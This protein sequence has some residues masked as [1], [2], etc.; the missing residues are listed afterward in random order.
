VP[1]L[2]REC[3]LGCPVGPGLEVGRNRQRIVTVG[4]GIPVE[5]PR[6]LPSDQRGAFGQLAGTNRRAGSGDRV[7][8]RGPRGGKVGRG[9]GQAK[10]FAAEGD[11][12]FV[13]ED[14]DPAALGWIGL[15]LRVEDHLA[16]D[17]GIAGVEEQFGVGKRLTVG[18]AGTVR[19][20]IEGAIFAVVGGRVAVAAFA[21]GGG[22]PDDQEVFADRV[23]VNFGGPDI[24]G[25]IFGREDGGERLDLS[26]FGPA[27]QILRCRIGETV[28]RPVGGPDGVEEAVVKD[29]RGIAGQVLA[30]P[31]CGGKDGP[32]SL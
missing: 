9:E 22:G 24:A 25:L 32:S 10:V 8:R 4:E 18:G 16:V 12:L 3:Q 28:A 15:S 27:N 31:E 23:P 1:R 30:R 20:M 6:V 11:F 13:L 21:F 14:Q 17:A 19:A 7:G 29:N 26:R 5:K 2:G